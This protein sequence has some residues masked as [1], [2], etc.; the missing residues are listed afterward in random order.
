MPGDT[1]RFFVEV[2]ER[3]PLGADV[4]TIQTKPG[5]DVATLTKQ[6]FL[7]RHKQQRRRLKIWGRCVKRNHGSHKG[8]GPSPY[9]TWP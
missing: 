7:E 2:Y 8:C 3:L 1:T 5:A 9:A 4:F 6:Q